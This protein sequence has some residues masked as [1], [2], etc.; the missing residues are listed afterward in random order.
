MEKVQPN[1]QG[2]FPALSAAA[3]LAFRKR[4]DRVQVRHAGTVVA[5]STSALTVFELGHTPVVYFPRGD[6]HLNLFAPVERSTHCPRKGDAS[7][8]A[9][10]GADG[11]VIAWSYEAPIEAAAP[12]KD[13]IA[14][15]AD[16]TDLTEEA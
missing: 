13:H 10:G 15:Y 12:L 2:P 9:F 3:P 7:Y 8:F 6:V 1:A 4:D 5:E 11:P 14:F 16:Q